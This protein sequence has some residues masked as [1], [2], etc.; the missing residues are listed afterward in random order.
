MAPASSRMRWELSH[1][2]AAIT[3][4]S[5]LSNAFPRVDAWCFFPNHGIS[6]GEGLRCSHWL[7]TALSTATGLAGGAAQAAGI[8]LTFGCSR[9]GD[10]LMCPGGPHTSLH[11][12]VSD[13]G[14]M[15]PGC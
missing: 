6:A 1:G 4:A 5:F 13:Y 3:P 11:A 15:G 12:Q 2:E 8:R 7:C 9:T 10:G 14:S